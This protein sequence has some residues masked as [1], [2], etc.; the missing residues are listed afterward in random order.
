[1]LSRRCGGEAVPGSSRPLG[2][3]FGTHASAAKPGYDISC[4]RRCFV[5]CCA[6]PRWGE[7]LVGELAFDEVRRPVQRRSCLVEQSGEALEDVRHARC[8]LERDR[9]IG[10]GCPGGEADGVAQ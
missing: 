6:T 7:A 1:M 2:A 8:D 9:D 5:R 3:T 4:S 10:E